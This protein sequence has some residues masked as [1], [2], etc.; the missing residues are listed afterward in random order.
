MRLLEI[1]EERGLKVTKDLEEGDLPSY[2]ILSHTWGP[3]EEEVTFQDLQEGTG[4]HKDGYGKLEFCAKQTRQDG[5][6]HFWVDTCCID[7]SNNVEL[8]TAIT[9]MFR[10]YQKAEKCYVYLS[11]VTTIH[12]NID[13]SCGESLRSD[14]RNCRWLRRGWT[15]QELLAPGV[16]EFFDSSGRKLGDKASL[17]RHICDTTGIPAEAL[18]GRALSSFSIEERL[19]W[20]KSRRTKKPEDQ[21]YSLSGICEV[22]M[23]PIYGEGQD[24]AMSRLRREIEEATRGMYRASISTTHCRRQVQQMTRTGTKRQHFALPFSL[25]GVAEAHQFVGREQELEDIHNSLGGD[26]RRRT[27]VLHGLGGMGKTQIAVAYA[28]RHRNSYSAVFW[29]NIQDETLLKRSFA[30]VAKRILQY[31]PSACRL[32]SIDPNGDL[33]EV[34]EAVSAWF[35]EIGNTRWLA[36]YDN[37]D[38]PKI[39]S[40]KDMAAV[41]ISKFLPEADQGSVIITTRSTL[42][43]I[44][45]CIAVRKLTDVHESVGILSSM[46]RRDLSSKGKRDTNVPVHH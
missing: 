27:V 13:G 38:N 30:K 11:D 17:E 14:F 43:R 26:G 40:N 3:D 44:G 19:S 16:V 41:D 1:T 32:S 33:H 12:N 15:L 8:N 7:K 29:F 24:K 4:K 2:A 5:Q 10:W 45:R 34:V 46:S 22:S 36:I 9:S 37:Y 6:R 35:S 23:I 28:R 20:Q 31:H 18:R 39:R 21:A 42:V 25:A